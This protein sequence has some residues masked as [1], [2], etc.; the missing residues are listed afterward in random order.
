MRIQKFI[1]G[2]I[3]FTTTG[4]LYTD[5]MSELLDKVMKAIRTNIT[6]AFVDV[7]AQARVSTNKNGESTIYFYVRY[8]DV[9]RNREVYDIVKNT[10]DK[11]CK[12]IYDDA[13]AAAA[14][15]GSSSGSSGGS[16]GFGAVPVG[17]G[18]SSGTSGTTTHT[19]PT[20]TITGNLVA[21]YSIVRYTAETI[22][23]DMIEDPMCEVRL[24]DRVTY[25]VNETGNCSMSVN[26]APIVW[27][28]N[29]MELI[30]KTVDVMCNHF[31]DS[32]EVQSE[33]ETLSFTMNIL[34]WTKSFSEK[35][36]EHKDWCVKYFINQL[37]ELN[38]DYDDIF[39]MDIKINDDYNAA[40]GTITGVIKVPGAISD[41]GLQR[42]IEDIR[43]ARQAIKIKD[44]TEDTKYRLLDIDIAFS[45]GK[46]LEYRTDANAPSMSKFFYKKDGQAGTPSTGKLSDKLAGGL[47]TGSSGSGR[48]FGKFKKT[49][50]ARKAAEAKEKPKKK[51]MKGLKLG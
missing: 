17:G 49:A 13:V 3:S 50:D 1:Y 51:W 43:R 7:K 42:R 28:K 41:Q 12:K 32:P 46:T 33:Y 47:G 4:D 16:G 9:D 23:S 31:M 27:S 15:A 36:M 19:V 2:N 34:D 45:N 26:N 10:L 20:G 11:E 38:H 39:N 35:D 25:N 48:G 30:R 40:N 5:K 21:D 6:E 24:K 14:S 22:W 44:R 18:S 37:K 29:K 8:E